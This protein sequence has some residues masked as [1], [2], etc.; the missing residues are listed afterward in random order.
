MENMFLHFFQLAL[1]GQLINQ[2]V[3]LLYC[4]SD[5]FEST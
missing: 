2:V 1:I 4:R 5:W 3:A